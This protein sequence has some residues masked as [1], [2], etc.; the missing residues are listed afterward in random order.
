M[1]KRLVQHILLIPSRGHVEQVGTGLLSFF[2]VHP[3]LRL[4][5]GIVTVGIQ[6]SGSLTHDSDNLLASRDLDFKAILL[7]LF[8][9]SPENR[10]LEFT[11]R[12]DHGH[13]RKGDLTADALRGRP[14]TMDSLLL[15]W[16]AAKFA[17]RRYQ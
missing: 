9:R 12:S 4:A 5:I 13:G 17:C 16:L 14:V 10:H 11:V 15:S 7:V 6:A 2:S 3:D 8:A 1:A